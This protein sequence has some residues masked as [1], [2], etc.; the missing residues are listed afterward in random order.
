MRIGRPRSHGK[1]LNPH[2]RSFCVLCVLLM[3]KLQGGD[4]NKLGR[5]RRIISGTRWK[6]HVRT[7][8]WWHT[9]MLPSRR[10]GCGTI[11]DRLPGGDKCRP[12]CRATNWAL[13]P[14]S[15]IHVPFYSEPRLSY[16]SVLIHNAGCRILRLCCFTDRTPLLLLRF[17]W[18][19][20]TDAPIAEISCVGHQGRWHQ[21][22]PRP[23]AVR[24]RPSPAKI[25]PQRFLL[26]SHCRRE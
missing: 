17:L 26:P 5:G 19:I 23:N 4:W 8:R 25:S 7:V 18:G 15:M 6:Y 10:P 24:W 21:L 22:E 11:A 2:K 9:G 3:R 20:L 12:V 16:R 14:I 13:S 1:A